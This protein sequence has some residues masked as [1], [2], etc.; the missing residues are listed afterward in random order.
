MYIDDA[1][2]ELEQAAVGDTVTVQRQHKNLTSEI[3]RFKKETYAQLGCFGDPRTDED[4]PGRILITL[5]WIYCPD[6]PGEEPDHLGCY[7]RDPEA[8]RGKHEVMPLNMALSIAL[9]RLHQRTTTD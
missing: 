4:H 5:G 7:W 6:E 3:L 1:L 9:N 8:P 2:E